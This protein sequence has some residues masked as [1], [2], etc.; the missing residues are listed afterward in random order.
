MPQKW[1]RNGYRNCTITKNK[2]TVMTDHNVKNRSLFCWPNCWEK[3][4]SKFVFICNS[5]T[6]VPPFPSAALNQGW[7]ISETGVR[8]SDQCAQQG[9]LWLI[10]LFGMTEATSWRRTA[11][12]WYGVAGHQSVHFHSGG[13]GIKEEGRG[14]G[15][16]VGG[17]NATWLLGLVA[18]GQSNLM[19]LHQGEREK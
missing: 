14:G 3:N 1:G 13:I 9:S 6:F 12:Q 7:L 17:H 2:A 19:R 5:K 10:W 4:T 15:V 16:S 18:R 8:D 11:A